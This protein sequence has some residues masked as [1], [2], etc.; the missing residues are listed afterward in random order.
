[1]TVPGRHNQHRRRYTVSMLR[2]IP[3]VTTAGCL[4]LCTIDLA[5]Y[6]FNGKLPLGGPMFVFLLIIGGVTWLS[7]DHK[8]IKNRTDLESLRKIAG[9]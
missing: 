1:M 8:Q 6:E 7:R 4:A 3:V 2:R 5:Y 9:K